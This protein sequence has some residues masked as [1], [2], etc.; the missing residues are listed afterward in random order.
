MV[1]YVSKGFS[2]EITRVEIDPACTPETR[3]PELVGK[4]F[5]PDFDSDEFV[6]FNVTQEF[7]YSEGESFAANTH[8]NDLLLLMNSKSLPHT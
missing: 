4:I 1:V 5:G 7:E 8:D 2:G 6:L 3:M